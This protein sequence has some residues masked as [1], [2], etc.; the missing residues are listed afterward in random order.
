MDIIYFLSSETSQGKVPPCSLRKRLRVGSVFTLPCHNREP[1]VPGSP[2]LV[3]RAVGVWVSAGP[4][5]FPSVFPHLSIVGESLKMTHLV[6]DL[7]PQERGRAQGGTEV[8]IVGWSVL[9]TAW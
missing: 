8:M 7:P 5:G 9:L 2:D 3:G 6:L 1:P 4:P